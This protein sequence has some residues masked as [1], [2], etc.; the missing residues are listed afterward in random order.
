[1]HYRLSN[2]NPY[3]VTATYQPFHFQSLKV[4]AEHIPL[5]FWQENYLVHLEN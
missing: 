5:S 3:I 1:M 2:S 4:M